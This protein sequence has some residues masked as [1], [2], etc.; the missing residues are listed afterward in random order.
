MV[1]I[2]FYTKPGCIACNIMRDILYDIMRNHEGEIRFAHIPE[3]DINDA[4][5]N[6][7]GIDKFPT[8]IIMRHLGSD[9]FDKLEGTA[10]K[11]LVESIIDKYDS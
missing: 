6:G 1:Q 3:K 8:I 10:T 7:Y 2:R 4:D 5:I 11:K 9:N